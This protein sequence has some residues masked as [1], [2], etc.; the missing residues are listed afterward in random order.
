M[1][2]VEL[3]LP[4][5]Q[6]TAVDLSQVRRWKRYPA[7]RDS[8]VEWLGDVPIGWEVKR[9]K[10]IAEINPVATADRS[11]K[12]GSE[13]S[14]V[15]MEAVGLYGGLD[16]SQSKDISAV[17]AGYTGF[18]DGDVLIAKITPCFE[19]GKGAYA[20]GLTNGVGFG[21]TELHVMRPTHESDGTF[22]FYLSIS[23]PF[24]L[25]GEG[26][27]YGA[28][29]QKRIS[30]EFVRNF[31]TAFPSLPEQRAIAAFLD[32]ETARI[33]TLIAKKER[34]IQLLHEKRTALI[35]HAVTKGLNPEAP[36]RDSGVEWLG[37]V[38]AGWEV[39]HLG[40]LIDSRRRLTYGIVQ[41][42]EPDPTGRFMIRGQDYSTGWAA[43]ESIFRVSAAV[44]EP[45][46]RARVR[47]GDVVMTIVGAGVGNIAVVPDRLSGA[48]LTQTTARIAIDP[49]RG[50]S[51]FFA[52][53]LTSWI[54]RVN[55]H[56]NTRG[57]AQPGL[58][59]A[60]IA[61]YFVVLPPLTEQ[62]TIAAFLDREVARI[63]GLMAKI[64]DHIARL[65]EYR[66]ALISAAVT[67]KIDVR[68]E[69]AA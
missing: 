61:K 38:P 46:R 7:Y 36:M 10:F 8:G 4:A 65:Q 43:P 34:L 20:E 16:L 2:T 66:T 45:Y 17:G 23:R 41:P 11:L 22:L 47:A 32:G 51:G 21:T 64:R 54:G 69:I 28:G 49:S 40:K 18:R 48:N 57:A 55:V 37:E 63:N 29:G 39:I 19:N 26:T 9:L 67:G 27:M 35:S 30:A 5:E 15:P 3:E 14:F 24:R 52:H 44:E 60:G 62:C 13:V 53:Q 42:G 6:V 58:T 50:D 25:L 33:N 12:A 31:E 59:L 56:L 1:S 68:G